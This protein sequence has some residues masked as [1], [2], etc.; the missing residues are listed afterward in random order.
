M[1]KVGDRIR[2]LNDRT[3]PKGVSIH[4]EDEGVIKGFVSTHGRVILQEGKTPYI[5]FPQAPDRL[6]PIPHMDAEVL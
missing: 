3:I 5:L 6:Y 4:I 2:L 1:M